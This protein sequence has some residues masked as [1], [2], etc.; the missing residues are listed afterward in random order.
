MTTVSQKISSNSINPCT[1]FKFSLYKMTYLHTLKRLTPVLCT[2]LLAACA[3]AGDKNQLD[4]PLAVVNYTDSP[5]G[6]VGVAKPETPNQIVAEGV[7]AFGAGGSMC[8]VS[9]PEKWY[10]GLELIVQTQDGIRTRTAEEW[11]KEKMPIIQH[12]VPVP[13]YTTLRLGRVWVQ[14][15]PG[16]KVVLVVSDL[17]PTDPQWPGE[18]KGWPVPTVEFRRKLWNLEMDVLQKSLA[19]FERMIKDA[20]EKE[21]AEYKWSIENIKEQIKSMGARP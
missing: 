15:L 6:W 3:H 1:Y 20:N 19:R 4:A 17:D 11:S 9:L 10:P 16:G 14:L 2:L 13:P 8:C 7:L 18:V 12:R 5:V 21:T